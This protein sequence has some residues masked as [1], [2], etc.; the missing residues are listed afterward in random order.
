MEFSYQIRI[1]RSPKPGN[2][3]KVVLIHVLKDN[4][5]VIGETQ[6]AFRNYTSSETINDESYL[7]SWVY[8]L[9]AEITNTISSLQSH[10]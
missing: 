6:V 7:S 1:L 8:E 4:G 5:E 2:T 9:P 10:I 3:G